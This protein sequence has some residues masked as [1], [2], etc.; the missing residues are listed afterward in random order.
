[1]QNQFK[2]FARYANANETLQRELTNI[3]KDIEN[4]LSEFH[5]V[6]AETKIERVPKLKHEE[7]STVLII[8]SI[9][10]REVD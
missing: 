1:M 9:T 4:D 6:H 2:V 5:I 8:V 7:V 3:N 10:Y